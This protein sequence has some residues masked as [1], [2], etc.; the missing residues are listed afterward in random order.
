MALT[1]QG[2]AKDSSRSHPA[3]RAIT[4][5]HAVE[6][7]LCIALSW[8]SDVA[9]DVWDIERLTTRRICIVISLI[10]KSS[11]RKIFS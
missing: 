7:R 5:A 8:K 11:Y 10:S 2:D 3:P 4:I 1:R 6:N 9:R